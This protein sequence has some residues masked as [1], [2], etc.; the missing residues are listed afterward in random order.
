MLNIKKIVFCVMVVILLVF[1]GCDNRTPAKN[2]ALQKYYGT[3]YVN[4]HVALN[5]AIIQDCSYHE[6]THKKLVIGESEI[7][8]DGE[9]YE[10]GEI[11]QRTYHD[12]TVMSHIHGRDALHICTGL[13]GD[14]WDEN[15]DML[16]EVKLVK[17]FTI[18]REEKAFGLLI[19]GDGSLIIHLGESFVELWGFYSLSDA[20]I[21]N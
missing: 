16:A 8:F 5:R 6:H 4:E 20:P 1:V 14:L 17:D 18:Q 12:I 19:A 7:T 9:S 11:E 13:W 10:I 3:W 2:A 15:G 21:K